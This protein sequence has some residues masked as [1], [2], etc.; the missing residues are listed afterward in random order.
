YST[1]RLKAACERRGHV[2]RVLN[3]LN[4][5]LALESGV[6]R[7]Y[8]RER[9][10]S[11]HDAVI[12]RIGASVSSYGTA[13]VRQLE[14][15]GV[16]SLNS[17]QAIAASRDKFRAFQVLSRFDIGIPATV[18]VRDRASIKS[19]IAQVGGPP[20]VIKLVEGAQG[21]GV[22]LAESS[23]SA[24]TILES[25]LVARQSVLVQKFVRESSGQDLRVLVVGDRVV[26]AMRRT[27]APDDFR[28]NV[29]RGGRTESVRLDPELE[30]LALQ[31]TQILGLRVAGV[32]LIESA[33]G[34]LVL[35]VNSSPG[36]EG[37]EAI[38]NEDVAGAIV[39]CLEQHVQ[40]PELD[41]RQRLT[42]ARGHA[43]AELVV[44]SGSE[45]AERTLERL[46]LSARD[47]RVLMVFRG[48]LSFPNPSRE[49]VLLPQDRL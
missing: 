19:A 29:H 18:L 41:L 20:L 4:F 15:L 43:V 33:H 36:L 39:E 46:E 37:I 22:I 48:A 3:T 49:F 28:S 17:S 5:S 1:R 2:A 16:F 35:E 9:P 30:R 47:V 44:A 7:I 38:T 10:L 14:Q 11:R 34:P 25:L 31:A 24:E 32:D 6:P 45:L 27:A 12:P 26:A 23:K 13:V 8:Y 21:A 40:F 42:A